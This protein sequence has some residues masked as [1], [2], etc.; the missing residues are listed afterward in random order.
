MKAYDDAKAQGHRNPH[1]FV[2]DLKLKGWYHAC[3]Y[4][5]SKRR[6]QDQWSVVCACSPRLAKRYKEVPDV[7]KKFLG[8]KGKFGSRASANDPAATSILPPA[9]RE[10][11]A[12]VLATCLQLLF[13]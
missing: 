3:I 4:K 6:K 9:F 10:L 7:L 13:S 5:W 2:K 12:E 8:K 11:M 1:R